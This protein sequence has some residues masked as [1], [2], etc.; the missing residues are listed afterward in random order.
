MTQGTVEE[1]VLDHVGDAGEL[2]FVSGGRR[3]SVRVDDALERALLEAKQMKVERDLEQAPRPAPSLPISSIQTLI[4][5]GAE[6]AAVASHYGIAEALVRRFSSAVETEKQYAIKQFLTVPAPKESRLRTVEDLINRMLVTARVDPRTVS[7]SATRRG[8]EPWRIVAQ[9]MSAGRRVKAEWTWNIHDN[10]VVCLNA[11]AK[12]LL[13]EPGLDGKAVP[14]IIQ[15]GTF[16]EGFAIPL[17]DA[18]RNADSESWPVGEVIGVSDAGT[19]SDAGADTGAGASAAGVS[20]SHDAP[21]AVGGADSSNAQDGSSAQS[22]ARTI[23]GLTQLDIYDME[24][25]VSDSIKLGSHPAPASSVTN[26]SDS[27]TEVPLGTETPPTPVPAASSTEAPANSSSHADAKS[28]PAKRK[29]RSAIPS[30]DEI[31][32]GD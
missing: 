7:W 2:V 21:D 14:S 1:A 10:T 6:P 28:K 13:G 22:H 26:A 23:G 20:V 5:A 11:T 27:L 15:P 25:V 19:T 31:L 17:E 8:H 29:G 12:K 3:F 4:R 30:W 16:G 18:Q 9:F 24:E 32:F